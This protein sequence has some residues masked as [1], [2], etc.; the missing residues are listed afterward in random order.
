MWLPCV[1]MGFQ[2][3][4]F[5]QLVTTHLGP[6]SSDLMWGKR[7]TVGRT[8]NSLC[9]EWQQNWF[10][11]SVWF[12]WINS[13]TGDFTDSCIWTMTLLPFSVS[14]RRSSTLISLWGAWVVTVP[15]ASEKSRERQ[16]WSLNFSQDYLTCCPWVNMSCSHHLSSFQIVP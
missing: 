3:M 15:A 16:F 14:R 10:H 2:Q 8:R 6:C 4:S 13:V 5:G 12:S 7:T 1:T 9:F 11:V